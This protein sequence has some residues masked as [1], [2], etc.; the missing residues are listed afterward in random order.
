MKK[1]CAAA[2]I[3]ALG[4][5]VHMYMGYLIFLKSFFGLWEI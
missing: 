2:K 3:S 5:K 4:N 1:T